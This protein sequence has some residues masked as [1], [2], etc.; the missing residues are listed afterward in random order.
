MKSRP[1]PIL[2]SV[3]VG[4]LL[5]VVGATRARIADTANNPSSAQSPGATALSHA[6]ADPYEVESLRLLSQAEGF[7]RLGLTKAAIDAVAALPEHGPHAR[8]ALRVR[9]WAL[10]AAG[11]YAKLDRLLEDDNQPEPEMRYLRGAARCR[12]HRF[13]EARDDLRALW[14]GSP[15]GIWGIAA[16]RELAASSESPYSQEARALVRRFVPEPNVDTRAA[17]DWGG[18]AILE[19]MHREA[20]RSDLLAAE[21]QHAIGVRLLRA[22]ELAPA[23]ALLRAAHARTT[24]SDLS[25]AIEL[26]LGEAERRRGHYATAQEHFANVAAAGQDPFADKAL[27]LAGQTA[28]E[29]GRYADARR[30]F[31]AQLVGNPVGTGR[32]EAL[33]GL[34]WVAFRTGDFGNARRFFASLRT[35]RPYGP[36]A[37]RAIY[38]GARA[39][40]ELGDRPGAAL[41]MTALERRF[42]VDY[43]AYRAAR[44]RDGREVPAQIAAL[45][46]PPP[47]RRVL[48]VEALVEA[49][50]RRRARKALRSLRGLSDTLGPHELERLESSARTAG[51]QRSAETFRRVRYERF[52]AEP[53]AMEH[54]A[55][56]FPA[57]TVALIARHARRQRIDTDLPVAVVL[58]ESGFRP[59]AVSP[60][61]AL[62]LMQLMPATARGLVKEETRHH[63]PTTAE[64]LDPETNVR[65][66]IKYLGRMIRAFDRRPEYALAAYNAGPGTVTRWREAHG[67]LPVDIFVE[68]IPYE[69]TQSYVRRVLC[70]L[71]VY[72]FV[73]ATRPSPGR[74]TAIARRDAPQERQPE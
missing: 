2:H 63:V 55:A 17:A 25:R 61:G 35:E 44:W 33:W 73:E 57:A 51:D 38:W 29:Y 53:A 4:V 66:G 8:A 1:R 59:N 30:H 11:Q 37:P 32:Q 5:A 71:Q 46:S 39:L 56:Q 21:L 43:Y 52:P 23:V 28:I 24:D 58:Q 69:E 13:D 60:V 20:P 40:E 41:E 62:G 9:A 36:L 48:H 65:L 45:P 47:D 10:L 22:E 54:L 16:L 64:I 31:Q 6:P 7:L 74:A 18:A 15:D 70:G 42:P 12:D 27:A 49:D 67:D 50:M 14:W 19:A 68:E 34:G 26:H 72:R 3:G